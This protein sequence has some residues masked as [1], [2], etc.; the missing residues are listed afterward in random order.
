MDPVEE[1]KL[2][3][4]AQIDIVDYI[5]KEISLIRDGV[6]FTGR[7]PFHKDELRSFSVD[8]NRQNFR[9]SWCGKS[10][11]IIGF[12]MHKKNI[13]YKEALKTLSEQTG[14]PL[15]EFKPKAR[16]DKI[17]IPFEEMRKERLEVR[18]DIHYEGQHPHPILQKDRPV[19]YLHMLNNGLAAFFFKLELVCDQLKIEKGGMLNERQSTQLLDEL[20]P[21]IARTPGV[22]T[23]AFQL[24]K[25]GNIVRMSSKS[26]ET[27]VE[28]F[29]KPLRKGT[30]DFFYIRPY[31][32]TPYELRL[33][34]TMLKES[35]NIEYFRSNINPDWFN[36]AGCR[37]I[38]NFLCENTKLLELD[39][40]YQQPGDE[41]PLLEDAY[42]RDIPAEIYAYAVSRDINVSEVELRRLYSY[43]KQVTNVFSASELRLLLEES[44][45]EQELVEKE[46]YFANKVNAEVPSI[47][48]EHFSPFAN[49]I[50]PEE[51]QE[52]YN[53]FLQFSKVY[54][55]F[56]SRLAK[57][58]DKLVWKRKQREERRKE[59][60][61]NAQASFDFSQENEK[62]NNRK[63]EINGNLFDQPDH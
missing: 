47:S 62:R 22:C 59:K 50:M 60:E 12:V 2:L 39:D 32:T 4:R 54:A 51:Y 3:L 43:I 28:A 58:Y 48:S 21:F 49:K 23:N 1:F 11:D 27:A 35:H 20:V 55:R 14:L 24:E 38:F 57:D 8:P 56:T 6:K 17:R 63:K 15:P 45:L 37:T 9:C 33:I 42:A 34:S 26:I 36:D 41:F 61:K 53:M 29:K 10:G 19:D 46:K 5:G 52:Y 18:L 31:H 30:K 7:C 44:H 25:L 13:E 16:P 40:T